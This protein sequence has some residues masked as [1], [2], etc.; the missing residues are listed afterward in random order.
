MPDSMWR[1]TFL[2]GRGGERGGGGGG[3]CILSYLPEYI[4]TYT[5]FRH[6]KNISYRIKILKIKLKGLNRPFRY[7]GD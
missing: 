2:P 5:L 4:H 3:G 7:S 1:V 6:G